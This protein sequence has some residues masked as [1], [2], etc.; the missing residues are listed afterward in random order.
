MPAPRV[1]SNISDWKASFEGVVKPSLY[2][3]TFA[4]GGF[5]TVMQAFIQHAGWDSTYRKKLTVLCETASF[6]VEAISTQPNRIYGP[7]REFAYEKLY[8]GDLSLIFRLDHDMSLRRFFTAWQQHIN[9]ADTADFSYY[10]D[11][12]CDIGVF[13]YPTKQSEGPIGTGADGTV[14]QGPIDDTPIYGVRIVE[15]YP[16]SVGPIEVGYE[17]RDT[18]M[19]QQVDFAFRRWEEIPLS[20]L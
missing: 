3:V 2:E 9:E 10:N 16:K 12:V 17:Q 6:P 7:I 13:Q 4:G 18:Y 11:Y 20:Q 8:S 1:P 19:K 15:A 5:E 14:I